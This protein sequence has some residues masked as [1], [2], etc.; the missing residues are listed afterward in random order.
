[1]LFIR[2][3]LLSLSPI[4]LAIVLLEVLADHI[5]ESWPM[6]K[7]AAWQSAKPGREFRGGDGKSYLTYK[8]SRVRLLKPKVLEPFGTSSMAG[9]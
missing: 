3:V 7:V 8:V 1:M 6:S 2:A 4:I 9:N 5:G